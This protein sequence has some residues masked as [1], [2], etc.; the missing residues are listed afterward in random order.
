MTSADRSPAAE[1]A[2]TADIAELISRLDLPAR[3]RLLTGGT[4]FTL[5][6]EP[7]IGLGE[8]RMSDGPTGVRG[9][10]FAG[11]RQVA[12]FPNA[13]LLA[14]AWS[15][16]T[17]AEVGA[18]LAEEALAQ[19]IH[20]VL[21][22]TINLHRTALGGRLFE[23][24]SEDPL[25]TGKLAAAYVRGMQ[26]LGVAACLKHLVANESETDRNTVNSVV[27]EAT[28]RELYLLPF[29]IA[30]ADADAWSMMA[31]YNDINGVAATEQNHIVNEVVKGEWGYSGV[32]MSD[33]FA[34]KT[35]AQ[36]ANGGLDLVMPGPDGPWGEALV[37]AVRDGRVA[38]SVVDD[39]LTRVLRLAGR[40]GALGELRS[41][42]ADLPTPGSATRREQ[43]TRLAA[44]GMTV[45]INRDEALPLSSLATVALIGRH[46]VETI[47]MGGGSATV[48]PPYQVSAAQGLRELMGGSV[49]VTDG[50][51]V[52]TRAVP[53]R[54]GFL[55]DPVT[56]APGVRFT[57]RDA[58]GAVIEE[59]LEAG[60]TTLVGID[61]E[62]DQVVITLDVEAVITGDGPIELGAIGVGSWTLQAGDQDISFTL[63][64]TGSIGEEMLA[65]PVQVE[66]ATVTAGSTLRGT[67][68]LPRQTAIT[69]DVQ[70]GEDILV[71]GAVLGVV[72]R[73]APRPA[74]DVIADAVAAA[75]DAE[76]AVVVVGLT[77]EQETE[78]VDKSTLALP[79][80]QDAMVSAVAAAAS[81]TVVVVNAATP[82]LMP[83]LD[84]VDAVLWVGLPGQEA[85]HAIAA[86][87]LGVI[88]P[89][90]RLVTT[91]PAADGASPAWAV[92][93]VDGDLVYTEGTFIGY[94]GHWA[95]LAAPPAF[96]L[97]HGLGY[98]SWEYGEA[99][100][101]PGQDTAVR[102]PVTNTSARPSRE[103]VQLYFAPAETD[104]PVRLVGW[105][106]VDVE[107][108]AAADVTVTAD[109]RLWRRWD[110]ENSGWTAL[111]GTGE[112]LVARGLGDV[113][114]RVTLQG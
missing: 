59:R 36:A 69:T 62:F 9:L 17:A 30:Q 58:D 8:L 72:A 18:M 70:D 13:T 7:V 3:V 35:A 39:H 73:P 65:P 80:E 57:L 92:E 83:W 6:P 94:R 61:D 33:W 103:V 91:F 79:G 110:T 86:A 16:D 108:G 43:M 12:L 102:V 46:A 85:G 10:K 95:Q 29:E 76:V 64:A 42:P 54:G 56:G 75:R 4:T 41:Y 44:G 97:G 14:S 19:E 81:R 100:L 11:G 63:R 89:A 90:G 27:D 28:L 93:P 40:V 21:G 23:A 47:T 2:S 34:T 5:A 111:S 104:Q 45:L 15:E 107:P 48:N 68:R 101:V 105:Q 88:E 96:W 20:V 38:E 78:S 82:I 26:G 109:A 55:T 87:L 25:L 113:R 71:G 106:A 52:R 1:T 49:T 50:V 112:L 31:A 99:A 77:E 114:A 74:A 98:G 32:I 67:V 22:P 24:Y 53:A 66:T 60:A 37:A 84:E 51:E